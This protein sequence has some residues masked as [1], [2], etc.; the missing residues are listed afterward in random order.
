LADALIAHYRDG[1]RRALDTYS[2]TCLKR[3][4]RAV[5]FSWWFTGLTHRFDD[6][7]F[8]ARLQL[9]ELDYIAGSRAAATAIA[10][11]YIGRTAT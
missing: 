7:A 11:N 5:R 8:A 6:D 3:V 9:A 1:D 10:E 4:W 2:E